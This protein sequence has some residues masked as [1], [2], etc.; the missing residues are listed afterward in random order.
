MGWII[1]GGI[2]IVIGVILFF[3]RRNQKNRA[4][5]I[6]TARTA[7]CAE[8]ATM[9]QAIAQEIGGGSW[10][11]YVKVSGAIE[12]DHPLV[13]QLRQEPC[14]HYTMTVRREYEETV[15]VKDDQGETRTE[16]RRSSETVSSNQQSVPF[17][18]QDYTGTVEVNPN[19]AEIETVKVLDEFHPEQGYGGR[20]SYGRF[21]L[22]VGGFPSG[23]RTLGYHYSEAIL[24]LQRRLF[25]VGMISDY[26][27]R[28]TLQKPTEPGKRFI[29][30]LKTEDELTRNADRMAQ[31]SFYAMLACVAIGVVLILIGLIRG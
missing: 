23:R 6:R 21:S 27:G 7:T 29:L 30:S 11:E 3:V 20:I 1:G 8:L 26:D 25:V 12:C 28:L 17:R 31:F 15:T 16:T 9:A 2:L 10:R 19:G 22:N 18:L 13:S 24:P 4:F 14:V 5:A